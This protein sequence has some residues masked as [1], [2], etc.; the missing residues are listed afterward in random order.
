MK[1]KPFIDLYAILELTEPTHGQQLKQ[2]FRDLAKKYHPDNQQTGNQERFI[3]IANV[4]KLLQ[5]PHW[6]AIYDNEY[7]KRQLLATIIQIPPDRIFY[8]TN[9]SRLARYGLMR[10]GLRNKDRAIL[11]GIHYDADIF[12]TREELQAEILIRY[13][14]TARVLCPE[15]KGSDIF[16][17]SCNG[18]GS[19]K[20]TRFLQ[21]H[22]RPGQVI[23]DTLYEF[24]L[25]SFRPGK[26][27]HFKKKTLRI[28][29]HLI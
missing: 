18:K 26:F 9:I 27:I 11:A 12:L 23:L 2:K 5:N 3:A 16:C 19:Y 13:P 22:F 20:S 21:I 8:T 1:K 15:C 24:S 14:L 29:L 28:K 10:K 7:Q 4:Y 25:S 6:K 17:S